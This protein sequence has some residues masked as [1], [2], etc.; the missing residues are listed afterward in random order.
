VVDLDPGETVGSPLRVQPGTI[1]PNRTSR[2]TSDAPPS[3]KPSK[4]KGTVYLVWVTTR[5]KF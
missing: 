5:P 2:K 3:P 4:D 1:F